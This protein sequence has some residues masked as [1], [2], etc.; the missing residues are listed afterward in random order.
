MAGAAARGL[1]VPGPAGFASVTGQGVHAVG[2]G[3]QVHIGNT[4]LLHCAG[5]GGLRVVMMTGDA[6]AT[7][8]AI[9]R[10]AGID[11]V[12]AEVR[13]E[14]KAA[15]IA[16]LQI[17]GQRVGMAGDGINDAPA[18]AQ[19]DVGLA[20]G[21]GTDVAIEAADVAFMSG[22]L[23]GIP[24]TI[25]LSR[26][27]IPQNPRA[28]VRLQHHRHPDRRRA[29]LPVLRHRP[30]ADDRRSRHGNLLAVS[31]HQR[32]PPPPRTHHRGTPAG[33]GREWPQP[34]DRPH[35]SR[36]PSP[37]KGSVPVKRFIMAAVAAA[38]ASSVPYCSRRSR[39]PGAAR[40]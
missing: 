14:D 16:R 19:A 36:N 17:E 8:D 39:W 10:Q 25:R 30:V 7:A 38:P 32:Q 33:H 27:N 18:L 31:G 23:V 5:V 13:V 9:A 11:R 29:A 34:P 26:A 20:I 21:T 2:A 37:G 40:C 1:V 28:G 4:R 15:E 3:H 6:R 35:P 24:A 12:L 22:S